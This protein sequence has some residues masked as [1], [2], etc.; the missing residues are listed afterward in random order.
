MS[1]RDRQSVR[2]AGRREFLGSCAS[3]LVALSGYPSLLTRTPLA[4]LPLNDQHPDGYEPVLRAIVETILPFDH[5]RFP[6]VSATEIETNLLA[7]FPLGDQ[8]YAPVRKGLMLFE[9]LDLFPLLQPPVA[10]EERALQGATDAEIAERAK[11]DERLYAEWRRA[12]PS[13]HA[14]RFTALGP[15]L[16]AGY[17]R[18]WGQSAFNGKQRFYHSLKSLVM[19]TAY[20]RA[21]LW[22]SIGYA[23]PL[24]EKNR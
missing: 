22:R 15:S 18:L 3:L 10:A 14:T 19:V 17:L 7:L 8:S 11:W 9:E 21:D 12:G 2:S 23:G 13:D 24:V 4:Q 1:H 20:S 16:R 6:R 5:P